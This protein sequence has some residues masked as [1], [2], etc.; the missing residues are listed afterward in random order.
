MQGAATAAQA[1]G[2]DKQT[3]DALYAEAQKLFQQATDVAAGMDYQHERA[4]AMYHSGLAYE[5][6]EDTGKA[7]ERFDQAIEVATACGDTA[8][9]NQ[10]RQHAA[11]LHESLGDD[12]EAI[13]LMQQ[14]SA[15]GPAVE[16]VRQQDPAEPAEA[17]ESVSGGGEMVNYLLEQ[18]RLLEKT[19]WHAQAAGVLRQALDLNQKAASPTLS[20]PIA[21]LLARS[22][23]GDGQF[24]AALNYL[25]VGM[26][27]TPS[28]RHE[29]ELYRAY[30]ILATIQRGRG[31]F[32]AMSRARERQ[33]M[34]L[35]EAQSKAEFTYESAL[36]RLAAPD[37]ARDDAVALLQ[38]TQRE[39]GASGLKTLQQLAT[40]RLCVAGEPCAAGVAQRAAEAVQASGLPVPALEARLLWAQVLQRE[41]Q[42]TQA[43]EQLDDLIDDMQFFQSR[44]PGVLGAWYWQNREFVFR[45]FVELIL[46]RLGPLHGSSGRTNVADRALTSLE[47]ILTYT[48]EQAAGVDAPPADPEIERLRSLIAATETGESGQD[49]TGLARQ[50]E[51][52]RRKWKAGKDASV[53]SVGRRLQDLA[54]DA[55][56]LTFYFSPKKLYAWVGRNR[57]LE[58]VQIPWS[59][60]QS[61][62][63]S[64]TTEALRWDAAN[65]RTGELSSQMD[66]LGKQLL[67]PVADLL[68]DVIYFFPNGRLEGFPLDALRWN[69]AYLAANHKVVNLTSLEDLAPETELRPENLRHI[70]LAGNRQER[71]G[72]FEQAKTP[73][74]EIDE[75]ADLFV[76]PGLHILQGAALQ[77]D[78]FQDERFN[79]AGVLHLAIP[80]I[81][82]LRDP[83]QSKLLL[84]DNAPE[85]S[86]AILRPVDIGHRRLDAALVVLSGCD[87][88]GTNTSA[89]TQNT[90]FIDEFLRSGAQSV[91]A[92]LWTVGD[93]QAAVF[94]RRFYQHLQT[95][96]NVS[97]ALSATKRS[98]LASNEGMDG[99]AWAAFQL[100]AR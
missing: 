51:Q 70:F 97:T 57:G 66:Q 3:A 72:D 37:S 4:R 56:L 60:D 41:G 88:T 77:W 38:K 75:L 68:P 98:Y 2:K 49:G 47:R 48:G 62:A 42:W 23:Y 61:A 9:A 30:G 28:F 35:T 54:D 45:A 74:A 50:I 59:A 39:A 17:G 91:V 90:R 86:R 82:D 14:I 6:A 11:E 12:S 26:K 55:A 52:Q 95:F 19:H 79:R 69:G 1:T 21:L 43:A 24:D 100:F 53:I 96:Q 20:G 16:E 80:G 18:G 94:M 83:G 93:T 85:P 31:D 8:L 58:L 89:F 36:D 81:I 33:Q 73:S 29:D 65:G 67:S 15:E 44:L 71:A 76:G 64:Q 32:A 7:F 92:S 34:F 46:E 63:L 78:E 22:L 5:S 84:S 87:F 25:Q 10:I 99:E 40:L 27:K 13:A